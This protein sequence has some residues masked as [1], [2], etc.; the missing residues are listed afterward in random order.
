MEDIILKQKKEL[1]DILD[2]ILKAPFAN[3]KEED[4]KKALAKYGR[5]EIDFEDCIK[6]LH[7]IKDNNTEEMLRKYALDLGTDDEQGE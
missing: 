3:M 2:T 6:E 5:K 4:I 7:M 1:D